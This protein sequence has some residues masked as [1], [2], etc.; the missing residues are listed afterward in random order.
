V[1][2]LLAALVASV[3]WLK[4]FGGRDSFRRYTIH[5]ERQA[6]DGL[7]V[8]GDVKLRGIKVGRVEDYALADNKLNRVRVEVR[9]DK[10]TPIRTNTVAV[11]TRNFVTDIAAIELV[12]REPPGPPLADAPPGVIGEAGAEFDELSARVARIGDMAAVTLNNINQLLNAENRETVLAT[13]RNLRDVSAG[14]NQR[15]SAIDRTLATAGGAAR[16]VGQA[17]GQLG[18]SGERV[19]A[20]AER[21]GER[22]DATLAEAEHTLADARHAI[23]Q[24]AAASHAMQQQASGIAR[25]LD[26]AASNVEDRWEAVANDLRTGIDAATRALDRLRDPR[27]ALLGPGKAQLGPGEAPP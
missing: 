24:L 10:R 6:L 26:D 1:L 14:L 11:V 27:A 25:R 7:E 20:V 16:E 3:L 4:D 19:A 18:R 2:V 23:Q 15:L 21:A 5:F 17:A 22:T 9:I 13:L 12:T 8:G